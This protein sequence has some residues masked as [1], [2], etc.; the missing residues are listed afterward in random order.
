[1]TRRNNPIPRRE[2]IRAVQY[3][4]A[5]T[6]GSRLKRKTVCEIK[7]LTNNECPECKQPLEVGGLG[8]VM[9]SKHNCGFCRRMY[10]EVFE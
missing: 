2:A 10:Y 8:A 4:Y 7:E 6:H 1:M 3:T 5:T 9:C